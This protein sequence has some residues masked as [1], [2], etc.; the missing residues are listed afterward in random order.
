[1][2]R[3][4]KNRLLMYNILSTIF[5]IIGTHGYLTFLSKY[6]EVQFNRS[7]ADALIVTGPAKITGIMIG[8]LAS[9]YVISKYKPKP[10]TLFMWNIFVGT[11]YV[12]GQTSYMF[13][14]CEGGNLVIDNGQLNLG[15][16]CNANC[17]CD[18]VSYSPVCDQTMD[19]TYFSACHAGC[20][21]FDGKEKLYRNCECVHSRPLADTL[22]CETCD[23]NTK[24][25]V[26]AAD[27]SGLIKNMTELSRIVPGICLES[28]AYAFYTFNC[29]ALVISML[30]GT[31]RIGS[32][33]LSLR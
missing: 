13:L 25:D 11:V 6:M 26:T 32:L 19:V 23:D 22:N 1:M 33:L 10:R 18:S 14:A 8:L 7:K 2:L 30:G 24:Y 16:K 20:K 15:N 27:T 28:C 29:I 5:F 12:L 4:I 17:S 3:L 31:A 9:G 21:E